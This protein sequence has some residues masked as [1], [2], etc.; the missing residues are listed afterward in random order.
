[1]YS[2]KNADIG[3]GYNSGIKSEKYQNDY[4]FNRWFVRDRNRAEYSMTYRAIKRRLK[5]IRFS[6]CLELGPG[7]GTWTRLLFR[8]NPEA[9]FDLVDISKEM[10]NQFRLEMRG[11]EK[12]KYLVNDIMDYE[13]ARPYDLFFSSRA[14]E[15]LDDKSAFFK[16]LNSLINEG[17]RGI[18]VTKN[19]FHGV[20]KS[21]KAAHQGQVPMTEMEKLL[22][23]NGFSDIH[24]FPAVI[25]LPIVSRFT[26]KLSEII[27]QNRIDKEPRRDAHNLI[28]ESYVVTFRASL[29]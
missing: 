16:K 26:S 27:F 2:L 1:M 19:P 4:E 25:R 8:A 12:V 3:T 23:E 7:P 20:R 5:G 14:V 18:I 10:Q 21:K 24:F 15:Y 6:N 28:M 22:R 13:P 9:G 11:G 29:K 17:G